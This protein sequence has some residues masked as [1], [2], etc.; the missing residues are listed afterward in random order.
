MCRRRIIG[1][2]VVRVKSG[3]SGF[4]TF[5][6][7]DRPPPFRMGWPLSSCATH[8]DSA[9]SL[10]SYSFMSSRMLSSHV[11]LGPLLFPCTRMFN[12][13]LVVSSPSFLNTWP[14]HLSHLFLRKVV[15]GS[16]FVSLQMSSFLM[17]SFLVLPL[18]HL[19]I[20][21]SVVCSFCVSYFFTAQHSD[22]YIIAGLTMVL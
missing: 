19:S 13:F 15:I 10:Q 7:I 9:P 2:C 3:A 22:P 12:I 18:A 6:P 21:I 11:F 1:S 16:M 14:Y 20:L 4:L 5:S 8:F 17:W